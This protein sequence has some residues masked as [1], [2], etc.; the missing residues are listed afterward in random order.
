ME[1][2]SEHNI[3]TKMNWPFCPTCGATVIADAEGSVRC[4]CCPFITHLSNIPA[5][6]LSLCTVSND[7][8]IPIWAK[9]DGA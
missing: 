2:P 6:K 1:D 3:A 5:S 8:M 9:S 4:P 7:T